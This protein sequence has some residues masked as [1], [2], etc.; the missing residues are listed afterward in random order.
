MEG[1][2]VPNMTFKILC[3]NAVAMTGT[4][5]VREYQC[6]NILIN[7]EN[8][9]K[10]TGGQT[11]EGSFDALE[12][13]RQIKHEGIEEVH[14][15]SAN[16]TNWK[17]ENGIQVHSRDR[18]LEIQDQLR[19]VSGISCLIYDQSCAA[20]LRRNRKRGVEKTPKS[21]IFINSRVCEG[22]G[23]CN[24]KSNCVA[25][26]PVDTKFGRKR[27]VDQSTSFYRIVVVFHCSY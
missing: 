3:N 8:S 1:R 24:V 13:A 2:A 6:V 9:H 10:H 15:V 17:S 4:F 22:C 5:C 7:T 20:E 18:F 12:I 16:P 21:R 11:P 26:G 23:D 27:A 25:I 14:I 19:G